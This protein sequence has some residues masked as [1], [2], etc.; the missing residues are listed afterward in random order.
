MDVNRD[1]RIVES[2]LEAW[3][4]QK[5]EE[6]F[7][8]A[9]EENESVFK[10]LDEDNDGENRVQFLSKVDLAWLREFVNLTLILFYLH[11]N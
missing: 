7:D 2:E 5:V 10:S 1:K 6:H 3:I 4:L 11:H 9:E 8:E